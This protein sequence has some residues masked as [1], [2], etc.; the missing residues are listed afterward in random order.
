MLASTLTA[1]QLPQSHSTRAFG[2]CSAKKARL[3]SIQDSSLH[4]DGC[5]WVVHPTRCDP[6]LAKGAISQLSWAL[7][8][9]GAEMDAVCPGPW[10]GH[11]QGPRRLVLLPGHRHGTGEPFSRWNSGAACSSSLVILA[12]VAAVSIPC[13]VRR[14]KRNRKRKRN[15]ERYCLVERRHGGRRA[16]SRACSGRAVWAGGPGDGRASGAQTCRTNDAQGGASTQTGAS[17]QQDPLLLLTYRH[18]YWEQ[19]QELL[20]DKPLTAHFLERSK[21]GTCQFFSQRVKATLQGITVRRQPGLDP[22]PV[23]GWLPPVEP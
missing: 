10:T 4:A 14:K 22:V 5:F 3:G 13:G 21:H 17:V 15:G 2:S 16:Q 18:V 19:P 12:E 8:A 9:V 7:C 6:S 23:P 20:G 1:Q 11:Q